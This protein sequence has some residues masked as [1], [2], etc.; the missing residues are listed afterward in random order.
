MI[1]RTWKIQLLLPVHSVRGPG[2]MGPD[3]EPC[4]TRITGPS[5]SSTGDRHHRGISLEAKHHNGCIDLE[6]AYKSRFASWGDAAQMFEAF[7][8]LV[9]LPTN[10]DCEPW[11]WPSFDSNRWFRSGYFV[12]VATRMAGEIMPSTIIRN[13]SWS[14]GLIISGLTHVFQFGFTSWGSMLQSGQM[15]SG[16]YGAWVEFTRKI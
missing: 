14:L 11:L 12:G 7:Y 4:S 1:M 13:P 15:L 2:G 16:V 5:D 10:L 9:G 6:N 3:G 8:A